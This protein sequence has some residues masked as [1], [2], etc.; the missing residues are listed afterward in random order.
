MSKTYDEAR[1]LA[2]SLA[3][4][5]L[6]LEPAQR[7]EVLRYLQEEVERLAEAPDEDTSES[8]TH[9]PKTSGWL[10]DNDAD[11]TGA[12]RRKNEA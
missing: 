9:E 4:T 3:V 2:R 12:V 10:A 1:Y 7:R 6:D 8:E 5:L 11:H